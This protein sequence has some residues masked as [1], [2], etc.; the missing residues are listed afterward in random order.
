MAVFNEKN[1]VKCYAATFICYGMLIVRTL[2]D[3]LCE[4]V[5]SITATFFWLC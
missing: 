4:G 1:I 5:L 2:V 3:F